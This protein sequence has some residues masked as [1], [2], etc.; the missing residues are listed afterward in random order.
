MTM[1]DRGLTRVEQEAIED[2]AVTGYGLD[3]IAA[4][5]HKPRGVI[6][7]YLNDAD[8]T[9]DGLPGFRDGY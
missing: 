8:D 2:M 6:L 4:Q 7:R 3:D 9:F 1:S 5:L